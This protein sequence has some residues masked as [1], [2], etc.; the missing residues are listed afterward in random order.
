MDKNEKI[1]YI[2]I[3][4]EKE[5]IDYKNTYRITTKSS[6]FRKGGAGT[7][8]S[9]FFADIPNIP[10]MEIKDCVVRVR[11]IVLPKSTSV[12]SPECIVEA[13]FLKAGKQYN[14]TFPNDMTSNVLG[15]VVLNQKTLVMTT[16]DVTN[17]I[18][19]AVT[20][21]RKFLNTG[22]V[23]AGNS[24]VPAGGAIDTCVGGVVVPL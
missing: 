21:Y 12:T 19:G 8:H 9:E 14:Q 1:D 23:L 15:Y 2:N 3:L 20:R 7:T 5:R 13:D 4:Q 22:E 24:A 11:S 16:Q 10:A 17:D 6:G 18:N